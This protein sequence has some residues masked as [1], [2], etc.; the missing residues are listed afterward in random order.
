MEAVIIDYS[1]RYVDRADKRE[2]LTKRHSK[3]KRCISH[4][5]SDFSLSDCCVKGA[6]GYRHWRCKTER[7]YERE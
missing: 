1:F 7:E 4:Q 2:K 5:Q 6:T 3:S